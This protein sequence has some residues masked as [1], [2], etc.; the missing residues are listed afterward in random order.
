[1]NIAIVDDLST[2]RTKLYDDIKKLSAENNLLTFLAKFESVESLLENIPPIGFE[3]VFL[4]IRFE[5]IDNTKKLASKIQELKPSCQIVFVSTSPDIA[6]NSQSNYY[7]ILSPYKEGDLALLLNRVD[8]HCLKSSRY[9]QVKADNKLENLLLCDILYT[10]YR[11]RYIQ[12]HTVTDIINVDMRFPKFFKILSPFKEFLL[13]YRN[14]II[15]MDKIRKVDDLFFLLCNG[16]HIPI[17]RR[18]MKQIKSH[19]SDYIFNVIEEDENDN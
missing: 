16:E 19:Y 2:N 1:M 7:I 11:S 17:N 5:A 12:I 18:H 8:K 13:C 10:E 15:N 9:I 4:A 3:V 14:I 6:I